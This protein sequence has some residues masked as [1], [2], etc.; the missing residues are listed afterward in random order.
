[1][2]KECY[3]SF[4]PPILF[5]SDLIYLV[6]TFWFFLPG[7][8]SIIIISKSCIGSANFSYTNERLFVLCILRERDNHENAFRRAN[9]IPTILFEFHLEIKNMRMLKKL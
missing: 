3:H 1:M 8:I 2:N 5:S 6:K 9:K 4:F 7:W